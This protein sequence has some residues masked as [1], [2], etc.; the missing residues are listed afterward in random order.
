MFRREQSYESE[1]H[2]LPEVFLK[3][4][5][6]EVRMEFIEGI[7][8]EQRAVAAELYKSDPEFQAD[9]AKMV[10]DCCLHDWNEIADDI[11]TAMGMPHGEIAGIIDSVGR[12][13][14]RVA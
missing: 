3:I 9:V 10:E 5:D 7:S 1:L 6:P 11:G 2:S 13:A 4:R 14:R 12:K 8:E